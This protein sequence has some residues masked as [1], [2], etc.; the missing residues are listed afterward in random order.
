[1]KKYTLIG[2]LV[3]ATI[4]MLFSST[5]V[6]S[7]SAGGF[8]GPAAFTGQPAGFAMPHGFTGGTMQVTVAQMVATFPDKTPAIVRGYIIGHLGGDRY[9]FRDAT[10]NGEVVIKIKNDRWWG[11]TVGPND[12]VELG[13]ELKREKNGMVKYF[14]AK[15]IRLAV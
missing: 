13:G 9:I 6:F 12:L 1:M 3:I 15:S 2:F 7:Q 11:L 14:D 4:A 8:V 10:G 5:A